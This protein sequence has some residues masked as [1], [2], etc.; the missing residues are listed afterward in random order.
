[1]NFLVHCKKKGIYI[2]WVSKMLTLNFQDFY[3]SN[4]PII[5]TNSIQIW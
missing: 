2:S 3:T 5:R 4:F 1:M